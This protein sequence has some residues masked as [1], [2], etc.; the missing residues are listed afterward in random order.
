M[1]SEIRKIP[2][3]ED[4]RFDIEFWQ[5]WLPLVK[6]KEYGWISF[7]FI[8]LFVENTKYCGTFEF[9]FWLLGLGFRIVWVYNTGKNEEK[10]SEWSEN[11]F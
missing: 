9:E 3:S 2:D 1:A 10:H 11:I 5:Q 8:R 6:P 7:E 4:G